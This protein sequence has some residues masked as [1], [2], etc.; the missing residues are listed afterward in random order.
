MKVKKVKKIS[1]KER[2][3]WFGRHEPSSGPREGNQP[4]LLSLSPITKNIKRIRDMEQEAIHAAAGRGGTVERTH[5]LVRG[6]VFCLNGFVY[7][8]ESYPYIRLSL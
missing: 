3:R 5:N 7:P 2:S 8:S 6:S 4:F 1:G